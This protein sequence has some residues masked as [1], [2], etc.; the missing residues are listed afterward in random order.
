MSALLS[1][2]K[3]NLILEHNADDAL[4]ESYITAAVA[5]AESYQHIPEGTYA[6]TAIPSAFESSPVEREGSLVSAP[7]TPSSSER[8]RSSITFPPAS[9]TFSVISSVFAPSF[10]SLSRNSSGILISAFATGRHHLSRENFGVHPAPSDVFHGGDVKGFSA[11]YQ[12]ASRQIG[13]V[14]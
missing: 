1:K 7:I 2:V 3:E 6:T 13:R 8:I 12:N 9:R 11:A 14:R 10:E 4:I 5:Y